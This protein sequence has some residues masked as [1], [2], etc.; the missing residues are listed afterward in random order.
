MNDIIITIAGP[1]GSGKTMLA[2]MLKDILIEA[3]DVPADRVVVNNPD[4]ENNT[5][6][7]DEY[8]RNPKELGVPKV[9]SK[10]NVTINEVQTRRISDV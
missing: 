4:G 10:M 3:L 7:M 6:M 1:V 5:I 9:F 2:C 8:L